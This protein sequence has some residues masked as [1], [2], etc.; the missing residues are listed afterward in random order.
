MHN[1]CEYFSLRPVF[2]TYTPIS[3]FLHG[4]QDELAVGAN[5]Q[6]CGIEKQARIESPALAEQV[7]QAMLPR[8][9]QRFGP[10]T[11]LAI[12]RHTTRDGQVLDGIRRDSASL[13]KC[14]AAPPITVDA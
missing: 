11:D 6:L 1:E 12:E 10:E 8:L 9:Q 4:Q 14:L 2:S 5:L 13:R 3:L 7:R